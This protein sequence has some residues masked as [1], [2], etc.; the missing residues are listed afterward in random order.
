[1]PA[2][3]LRCPIAR[4]PLSGRC[5]PPASHPFGRLGTHSSG[6]FRAARSGY[7]MSRESRKSQF[8]SDG[9]GRWPATIT[10]WLSRASARLPKGRF[11]C[12]AVGRPAERPKSG[13]G[14]SGHSPT[15]PDGRQPVSC[16]QCGDGDS[17]GRNG[18]GLEFAVN[19]SPPGLPRSKQH[20]FVLAS[21]SRSSPP[22]S[23]SS[24][25]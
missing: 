24:R 5:P 6:N 17:R 8:A 3:R 11:R 23:P 16:R 9:S 25:P 14:A 22:P 15:E 19:S 1:M 12:T 2:S 20:P 21:S 10:S 4:G 13:I 7:R 18:T